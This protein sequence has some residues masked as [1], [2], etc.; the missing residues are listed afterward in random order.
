MKGSKYVLEFDAWS[1][2]PRYIEVKVAQ[3]NT[4]YLSYSGVYYP[5]LGQNPTHYRYPFV[6]REI[7]D[8]GASIFF[9]LGG[10]LA[11]VFLDNVSLFNVPPGDFDLDGKVTTR[12]LSL[13]ATEWLKQQ[14]TLASDLDGN[15]KVD[16]KDFAIFAENWSV[17]P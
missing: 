14:G 17:N 12:D 9:G 16:F 11:A 7:S 10:A 2:W 6:M 1:Q 3:T 15:G 5:S 13:F 4:P 8:P